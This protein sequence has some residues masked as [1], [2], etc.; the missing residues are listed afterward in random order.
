[1]TEAPPLDNGKTTLGLKK[2]LLLKTAVEAQLADLQLCYETLEELQ[3][4]AV[5]LEPDETLIARF[6]EKLS[7]RLVMAE[8][9][10]NQ[11]ASVLGL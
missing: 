7:T 1:M 10:R 4:Q 8:R 9:S 11:L 2:I 5:R 3:D 6:E